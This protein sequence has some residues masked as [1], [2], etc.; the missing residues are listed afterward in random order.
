ML[1]WSNDQIREISTSP[2][3]PG[4]DLADI[5]QIYGGN[6]LLGSRK[7]D[8]FRVFTPQGQGRIGFGDQLSP[9]PI[10]ASSQGNAHLLAV[11]GN[12]WVTVPQ[13]GALLE[14]QINLDGTGSISTSLALPYLNGQPFVANGLAYD[15][16]TQRLWLVGNAVGYFTI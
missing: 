2:P 14:L 4:D 12:V 10:G 7:G 8:I 3:I 6:L 5:M 15:P 13:N 9:Y 16:A 11:G 1:R